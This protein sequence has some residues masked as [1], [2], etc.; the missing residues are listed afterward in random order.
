MENLKGERISGFKIR[1]SLGF[2]LEGNSFFRGPHPERTEE[3]DGKK[4]EGIF[5]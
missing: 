1:S 3:P 2:F 4:E 5:S